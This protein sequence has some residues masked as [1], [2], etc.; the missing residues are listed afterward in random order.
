M[1]RAATSAALA[2]FLVLGVSGCQT[3]TSSPSDDASASA[4]ASQA[5]YGNWAPS[6]FHKIDDVALRWD[7]D[8]T[9]DGV[10]STQNAT[11]IARDGCTSLYIEINLL[12]TSDAIVGYTNATANNMDAGQ[13]AHLQFQWSEDNVTKIVPTEV[14]CN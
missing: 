9:N 14:N 11:V 10:F 13:R 6:G 12:D 3:D 7:G 1:L 4:A 5:V 8:W 2:A